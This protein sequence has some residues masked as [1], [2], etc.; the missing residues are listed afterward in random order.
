MYGDLRFDDQEFDAMRRGQDPALAHR[1]DNR[2]LLRYHCEHVERWRYDSEIPDPRPLLLPR[3][4]DTRTMHEGLC[5]NIRDG[6]ESPGP[7]GRRLEDLDRSDQWDLSRALA[8]SIRSGSYRPGRN[9]RLKVPKAAKPGQ[10][11]EIVIQNVE[12]RIVGRAAKLILDPFFD[13]GF[14]PYNFGYRPNLG[15][16][17]ALATAIT[18]AE[19]RGLWTWISAD[20]ANAFDAVPF[21]RLIDVLRQWQ[22]PEDLIEFLKVVSY[23]GKLRGIPQGSSLSPLLFN[24]YADYV[25]DKSWLKRHLERLLLRFAD[26]LLV[27]C[28]SPEEAAV[29]YAEL[30]R[31]CRSAGLSLKLDGPGYVDLSAGGS[32]QWLGY[33]ITRGAGGVEINIADRA[34]NKLSDNLQEAHLRPAPPIRAAQTVQGWLQYIGPCVEFEDRQG[35]LDRVYTVAET[36]AFNELPP[37]NELIEIMDDAQSRWEAMQ[38]RIAAT[39][40]Y[41][42]NAGADGDGSAVEDD[43]EEVAAVEL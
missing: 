4:A 2:R 34:W 40:R 5:D 20:V 9:R 1:G 39:V 28:M 38:Q 14:S 43:R 19:T 37:A 18:I 29:L 36:L 15:V 7:N 16:Q 27:P 23:T 42:L 30:S 31:R 41:Q 13:P 22:L 8:K 11:R 10:F 26:D 17:D 21:R 24:I 35:I 12:D 3:I 33:Q 6:G 32:I 25:L